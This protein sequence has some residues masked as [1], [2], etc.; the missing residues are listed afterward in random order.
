[1]RFIKNYF[2]TFA[3]GDI[4]T[5]ISYL[6]M[7][8]GCFLRG[9]IIKGLLFL[10]LQASFIVYLFNFGLGQL[11]L[12]PTLGTA[13]RV[14]VWNEEL[15][16]YEY[17][18]GDNSMLILLFSVMTIIIILAF[19]VIYHLNI[20]TAYNNQLTKERGG[21]L[22]NMIRDIRSLFDSNLHVTF[23]TLPTIGVVTFTILP[24]I[25]MILIAFTN[26]DQSHQPP[27][28]LFTWVGLENFR[29]IFWN[30]PLQARTFVGILQWT[31]IWAFFA[32]F[33]NYILGMILALMINKKG[34]RL[35]KLWRTIFVMTIAVPQFVSLML[36]SRL[37]ADQGAM[38]VLLGYLGIGPIQFLTN[39]LYARITVIVVNIWVGVP[40]TMLITSGILMNIPADLYE[41]ARIDGANP[42][43]TFTRITLPYMLF[44]TTPYLITQFVGNINNFNVIY[45]L[46]GGGPLSLDYYQAGKTDLL[47]TWLYKLTVNNQD[48][49]LASAIGI[50]IFAISAA[51]SLIVYNMSSSTKKEETFQ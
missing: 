26:Y 31:L 38:N 30:D 25:F 16:I 29:N 40:Y 5:K 36:M 19:L 42:V 44:V 32:T 12:L 20:K 50:I 35:K 2:M 10:F 15:Q 27:G 17:V 39:A 9:Q 47:V 18:Q 41:S 14:E 33:S 45:L 43:K 46:T 8:A 49:N 37:L 34:I 23:L 4:I 24:L 28:N 1:M 22:N 6:I 48:Y 3:A 21:K 7:G 51:M 11:K 13:T